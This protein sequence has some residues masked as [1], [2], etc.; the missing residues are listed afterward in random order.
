MLARDFV[1]VLVL[2]GLIS[3]MGYLIVADIASSENG[4]DVS[5]MTDASYTKR[6]DTLTNSTRDIG[7]MKNASAS[8][9]GINVVSTYTTLFGAT[10]SIISLVLGSFGMVDKTLHNF[11]KD[12]GMSGDMSNLIFGSILVILIAIIVFII[13]SSV[14]RGRL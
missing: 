12:L 2:F 6:Y 13:I 7:K 3:G 9:E 11:G 5:N 4:Y 8:N 14:S 1:I 10:F